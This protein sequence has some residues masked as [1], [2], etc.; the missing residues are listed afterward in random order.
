MV[1]STSMKLLWWLPLLLHLQLHKNVTIQVI[2]ASFHLEYKISL[3]SFNSLEYSFKIANVN[4]WPTDDFFKATAFDPTTMTKAVKTQH[5]QLLFCSEEFNNLCITICTV[6]WNFNHTFS[7]TACFQNIW[8][9]DN[10]SS[11]VEMY[12]NVMHNQVSYLN[13]QKA[14]RLPPKLI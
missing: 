14:S 5:K 3:T 6:L 2:I 13:V 8:C 12:C 9:S 10:I 4:M 1:F 7:A 11:P